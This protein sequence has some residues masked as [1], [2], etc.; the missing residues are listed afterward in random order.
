MAAGSAED[1]FCFPLEH[2]NKGIG[3]HWVCPQSQG[4]GQVF[5]SPCTLFAPCYQSLSLQRYL[6]ISSLGE[7]L[8]LLTFHSKK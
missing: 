5:K 8:P 1:L 2:D 7:T 4:K 6:L 3:N